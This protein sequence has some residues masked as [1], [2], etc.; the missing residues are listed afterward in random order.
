M[1]LGNQCIE[2]LWDKYLDGKARNYLCNG[3]TVTGILKRIDPKE[4]EKIDYKLIE[5][6]KSDTVIRI[7]DRSF[8]GKKDLHPH[9][10]YWICHCRVCGHIWVSHW[11]GLNEKDRQYPKRCANLYCKSKK[12]RTG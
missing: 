6:G 4:M 1:G 2:T 9:Q 10:D 3:S 5:L 11:L 12:W 8:L 7:I